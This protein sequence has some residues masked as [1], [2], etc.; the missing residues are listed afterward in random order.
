MG[1]QQVTDL[2]AETT[3]AIGGLNKKTG[4]KN[5][6]SV[7]GYYLGK[8]QVESKKAKS[9]F[10]FIYYFQTSKGNIGVWGKT[11]LDR[12]MSTVTPGVMV[13][14]SFDKMVPT[15]NGDM[16]KFKVEFDPDNTIEVSAQAD[17]SSTENEEAANE[18]ETQEESEEE[19]EEVDEDA[20]QAAALLA[21]ERK[22]KVAALLK[23]NKGKGAKG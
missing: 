23:G 18:E 3:V 21:A 22:A 16:Y 2:D 5:P 14:A 4:K 20:L 13:R 15:P 12:K 6:T 7:E 17:D 19:T 10:A 9:G 1:F 11:D 8:R